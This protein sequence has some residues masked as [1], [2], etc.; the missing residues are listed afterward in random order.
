[1]H[2]H[3]TV[4]G[5]Q[6]RSVARRA[7]VVLS[8]LFALFALVVAIKWAP[9]WLTSTKGLHGND[10]AQELGRVRTAI[11]AGLAGLLAA[12]GGYYTHRTFELNRA[13]QITER[14]TRAIDQLGNPQIDVRLGGIY[15][16][17]RIARDSRDYHP[18]VIEV[19]SAYVR[20]HAPCNTT[21]PNTKVRAQSTDS[22]NVYLTRA[23]IRVLERITQARAAK[24][25]EAGESSRE[26]DGSQTIEGR[27]PGLA[28]DVQA[29]M[30][31]LARRNRSQDVPDRPRTHGPTRPSF[32]VPGRSASGSGNFAGAHLEGAD[33]NGAHLEGAYFAGAHLEGADLNGAHLEGANLTGAYLERGKLANAHLEEADLER[34][35]LEGA[36]L[37]RAHLHG[38]NLIGAHMKEAELTWARMEQAA[39]G[40]AHLEDAFVNEV[41]L[42]WANLVNA[43]MKGTILRNSD[44]RRA[45]LSGAHL[46]GADL[47]KAHLEAAYLTGTRLQNADLSE[48]HLE[49]ADLTE[50]HL[51]GAN[52]RGA[53]MQGTKLTG[54]HLRD[55]DLRTAD[56]ADL[57]GAHLE[58]ARLRKTNQAH[59]EESAVGPAQ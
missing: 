14:F 1:M 28:I 35:H 37:K 12:L 32:P 56:D 2:R 22:P 45:T 11:L 36:D 47:T 26:V 23:A 5:R 27:R 4:D 58:G 34:A 46:E 13:G 59:R 15:A 52:L 57:T 55:A 31:A 20:G 29:A 51:E 43:H 30:T 33:L 39:L 53:K 54:A 21:P 24:H 17:E 6:L 41:N 40:E 38:A 48:A 8:A 19:L 44:L 9:Q 16:L 49:A 50:A 7:V 25:N 18:Q 3:R 10:K 42:Q